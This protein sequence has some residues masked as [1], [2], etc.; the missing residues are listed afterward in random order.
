MCT[1]VNES[2]AQTIAPAI[3][4]AKK[5]TVCTNSC[6]S[7]M[8]FCRL[9]LLQLFFFLVPFTPFAHLQNDTGK[10]MIKND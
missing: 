1:L 7:N 8:M 2:A 4:E 6:T 9:K 3:H 10:G 5:S